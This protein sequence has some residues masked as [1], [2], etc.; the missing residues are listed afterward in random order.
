MANGP[1]ELCSSSNWSQKGDQRASDV[2]DPPGPCSHG[3]LFTPNATQVSF[4]YRSPRGLS[5]KASEI[6]VTL[7]A[8]FLIYFP[9]ERAQILGDLLQLGAQ[10]GSALHLPPAEQEG[11]EMLLLSRG[12]K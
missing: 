5:P 3:P 9:K 2:G 4:W 8:L 1:A 6:E 12:R 10:H 7:S 11:E